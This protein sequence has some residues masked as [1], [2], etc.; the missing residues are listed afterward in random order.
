MG[1][2]DWTIA[3]VIVFSVVVP[4]A[5]GHDLHL[6]PEQCRQV[7]TT[8]NITMVQTTGGVV[9]GAATVVGKAVATGQG[10]VT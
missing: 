9:L 2:K 8:H 1:L 4:T 3:G 7:I 5:H 10:T 6:H